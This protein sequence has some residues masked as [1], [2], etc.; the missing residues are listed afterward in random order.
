MATPVT[1]GALVLYPA[2]TR[3]DA[4]RQF[5]NR[6]GRH[7]PDCSSTGDGS[8]CSC[9]FNLAVS[10]LHQILAGAREDERPLLPLHLKRVAGAVLPDGL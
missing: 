3:I 5:A 7:D 9:G 4:L 2:G 1:K 8:P 10:S 6:W